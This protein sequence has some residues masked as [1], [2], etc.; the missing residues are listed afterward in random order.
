MKWFSLSFFS[1]L[2][3]VIMSF[4][5][6]RPERIDAATDNVG[7]FFDALGAVLIFGFE[8]VTCTI[9]VTGSL[10]AG[11]AVT[12]FAIKAWNAYQG[13]RV[14]RLRM[15]DGAFPLIERK[16]GN[17]VVA[18]WNPNTTFDD[19]AVISRQGLTTF[20]N[21]EYGADRRLALKLEQEKTN[22]ARSVFPGDVAR[23]DK[24]G[25]M[26]QMPKSP[27]KT[28]S[29]A[30]PPKL[31]T[32][33][34]T[35][36]GVIEPGDFNPR[37]LNGEAALRA[38]RPDYWILGQEEGSAGY[39]VFRPATDVHAAIVGATGSGKTKSIGY[40]MALHALRSGG[41]L[42]ILDADG[43]VDWRRFAGHAEWH[44]TDSG[45]FEDQ[46]VAVAAEK[47]RRD[48]I[49]LRHDLD[50]I[51]ADAAVYADNPR[52]FV[53][54]EE[55]GSLLQSFG[56]RSG[57]KARVNDIL[58]EL[59]RK[60]RKTGI[61]IMLFDQYPNLWPDQTLV[62]AK[63]KYVFQIDGG[64]GAKVSAP[65]AGNLDVGEFYL[66][67][68]KYRSFDMAGTCAG[69]LAA[70]PKTAFP[71]LMAPSVAAEPVSLAPEWDVAFAGEIP[72]PRTAPKREVIF[73]WRNRYPEYSQADFRNW[74]RAEH[75]M[76][77][78]RGYISDCFKEWDAENGLT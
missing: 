13:G 53:I 65:K 30:K 41:R 27:G 29:A 44:E 11:V 37:L 17:G 47:A 3:I 25:H 63:T 71:A 28:L 5:A 15:E 9:V 66:R 32:A 22:T 50:S 7:S 64:K 2:L 10:G 60:S 38:S 52:I 68:D 31:L 24:Y 16:L 54:V 48:Q 51:E 75:N 1:F 72:N 4:G 35:P 45:V 36:N 33:A 57:D 12:Y 58:D 14:R 6:T 8:A 78:G 18:Y 73:E 69:L 40:L 26:S 43:G 55:Y 34:T 39:A 46:L 70:T 61:H 49:L 62:N 56:Q 67:D 19:F 59:M 77:Y 76:E 23:M 21:P 20:S 74:L 42:I